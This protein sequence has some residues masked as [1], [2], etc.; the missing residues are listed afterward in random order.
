MPIKYFPYV[1]AA[2]IA[3]MLLSLHFNWLQIFFFG[4]EHAQV[5]GI[6]YFSAPKSFLNLLEKRS[7]FDSW[8]GVPYGPYATWYLAHPAFGVF[9]AS[10]G[11]HSFHPGPATGCLSFFHWR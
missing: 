9:I 4:A 8:K 10:C 7:M 3:G 6:D 5:Q 1:V 2:I 11:F